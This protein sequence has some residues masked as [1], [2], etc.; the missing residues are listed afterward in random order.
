MTI[1]NKLTTKFSHLLNKYREWKNWN[2]IANSMKMSNNKKTASVKITANKQPG[3][4]LSF[5]DS[6][7]VSHWYKYGKDI[8]GYYDIKV[9]FN[10]NAFHHF[11]N[12]REHS[13]K[14]IDML[15]ELQAKG[16][17]IAHHGFKHKRATHHLKEHGMDRWLEDEINNLFDWVEKQTHSITKEKFHKPVTY[18]F[19]YFIYNENL[20]NVLTPEYFK[21]VRGHHRDDNLVGFNHTG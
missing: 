20:I 16:H 15:L 19:P 21:V 9:T 17:E 1:K 5:D 2:D 11:E 4:A 8:F 3:I 10:I 14:E 6:F 12:Q 18:A 13:Q 7:R